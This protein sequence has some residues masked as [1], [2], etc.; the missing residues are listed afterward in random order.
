MLR[1][2]LPQFILALAV[3]LWLG[4][5]TFYA[6]IVVPIGTE[7]V[8]GTEQGF[9]TQRVT[10]WLN[11]IGVVAILGLGANVWW[12]QRTR[13]NVIT[14]ILTAALQVSLLGIHPL[15]DGQ[16]D[17]ANRTVRDAS[18]FYACHRVYLILTASIW[19]TCLAHVWLI[20]RPIANPV[21]A[22]L[23]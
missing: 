13:A 17:L 16:L 9:I 11:A 18:W 1:D 19:L 10:N 23:E 20:G 8:G 15:L 12:R 22:P 3:G 2:R 6:V 14:W 5:L 4:G 21:S 7:I